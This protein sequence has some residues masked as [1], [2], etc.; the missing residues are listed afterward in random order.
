MSTNSATLLDSLQKMTE[1]HLEALTQIQIQSD[2]AL[3]YS[4]APG[5]WNVLQCIEHLNRYGRFYLP[6]IDRQ[7]SKAAYPAAAKFKS[8]WLGNYFAKAMLPGPQTKKM[9]TFRPMD[10]AASGLDRKVLDEFE[11]QLRQMLQLL[12]RAA[13]TDLNRVKTAISISKLLRL[14]LGDTLQ[15]VIYHNERH[16]Q[17]AA[18]ALQ[19]AEAAAPHAENR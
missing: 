12:D 9:K 18:R 4:A 1:A 15:V 14:K 3:A 16:L 2:A 5:S 17:Q 8:G 7:L 19:A 13:G 10:P 6:E 11:T